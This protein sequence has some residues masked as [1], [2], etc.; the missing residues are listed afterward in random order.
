[1]DRCGDGSAR[2]EGDGLPLAEAAL[3]ELELPSEKMYLRI[4]RRSIPLE[5]L[6]RNCL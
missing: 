6:F 1:M 5:G 4:G 2:L 3:R